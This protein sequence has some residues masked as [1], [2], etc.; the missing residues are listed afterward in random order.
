MGLLIITC[1]QIVTGLL[2]EVEQTMHLLS[3]WVFSHY[4][5][6]PYFALLYRLNS[7]QAKRRRRKEMTK[8]KRSCW[9]GLL[10]RK[11]IAYCQR[12]H[13]DR[14]P[15]YLGS[16]RMATY[17]V[18]ENVVTFRTTCVHTYHRS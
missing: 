12:C 13:K 1:L 9:M 16:G 11:Q 10:M 17:E 3:V 14:E 2:M 8:N 5:S 4:F 6:S 15:T 7:K 18:A